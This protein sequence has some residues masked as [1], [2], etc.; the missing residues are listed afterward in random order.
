MARTALRA[1]IRGRTLNCRMTGDDAQNGKITTSC[2]VGKTD[3]GQWLVDQGWT[4]ST[5]PTKP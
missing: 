3:I 1:L 5:V 2:K 4:R